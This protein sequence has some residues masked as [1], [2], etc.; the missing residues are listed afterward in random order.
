MFPPMPDAA[1]QESRHR[2]QPNTA[3]GNITGG[4][5]AEPGS[6][7]TMQ[8]V[9]GGNGL[10]LSALGRDKCKGAKHP[11]RA[12]AAARASNG[13]GLR[14]Y[15]KKLSLSQH[16]FWHRC[17]DGCAFGAGSQRSVRRGD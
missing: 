4:G 13:G 2:V 12:R 9:D 7:V 14:S 8:L 5:R 3:Y 10:L 16:R 1:L 11:G 6:Y 17:G 15:K